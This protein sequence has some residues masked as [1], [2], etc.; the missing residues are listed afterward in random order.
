MS[1][2]PDPYH[3]VDE[4]GACAVLLLIDGDPLKDILV[5][6]KPERRPR[7]D[8]DRREHLQ[9]LSFHDLKHLSENF[10]FMQEI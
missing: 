6:T 10:L 7:A 2:P 9:E 1:G 8:H 5:P 4:K 3:G